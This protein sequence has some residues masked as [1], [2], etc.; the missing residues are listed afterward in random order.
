MAPKDFGVHCCAD[1][2]EP[3]P[4]TESCTHSN[5]CCVE[6]YCEMI[7]HIAHDAGDNE[8]ADHAAETATL[9]FAFCRAAA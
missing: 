2:T 5:I 6:R 7:H 9:A 3:H 8:C 4:E 1:E